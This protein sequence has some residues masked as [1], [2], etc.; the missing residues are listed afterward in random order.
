MRITTVV[1][2]LAELVRVYP[3]SRRWIGRRYSDPVGAT[4]RS[5]DLAQV[6]QAEHNLCHNDRKSRTS[7]DPLFGW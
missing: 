3:D 2:T 7:D 5:T 6:G 1:S 4:S